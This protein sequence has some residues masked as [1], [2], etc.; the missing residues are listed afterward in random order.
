M[1]I[2]GSTNYTQRLNYDI[3]LIWIN[4]DVPIRTLLLPTCCAR[5]T[6]L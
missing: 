3:L 4:Q 1:I 6:S 2:Y 5:V